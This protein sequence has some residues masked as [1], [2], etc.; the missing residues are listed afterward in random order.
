MYTVLT[1]NLYYR[2]L[3]IIN[4][5]YICF[6]VTKFG[7]PYMKSI[8]LWQIYSLILINLYYRTQWIQ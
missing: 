7:L 8:L 3:I 1:L 2:N 6:T 5:S 4:V